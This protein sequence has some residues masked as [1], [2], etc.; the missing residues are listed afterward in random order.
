MTLSSRSTRYFALALLAI[1]LLLPLPAQGGPA[2]SPSPAPTTI[3]CG[4]DQATNTCGGACDA[5]LA[6][7]FVSTGCEC[8]PSNSLCALS[9]QTTGGPLPMCLG[10][11]PGAN[12]VCQL[13]ATRAGAP[14]C[15][16]LGQATATPTPTA[17]PTDTATPTP[18][19]TVT[20]TPTATPTDTATPSP[21][22][23]ATVAAATLT[24]PP[25]TP[26]PLKHFAC[27]EVHAGPFEPRTVL[28]SDQ[29]ND[30]QDPTTVRVRPPKR[31]CNPA[32]KNDEDPTALQDPDHLVAYPI[33]QTAPRFRTIR[34][35]VV[36]DQFGTLVLDV[37]R[38][39]QLLVPSAKSDT[40]PPAP[41]TPTIDHFKCYRVKGDRRR[42]T[43]VTIDDQFGAITVDIKRPRRLC[44]PAVKNG[45]GAL[46]DAVDH[47]MCYEVRLRAGSAFSGGG[48][49]FIDNQ[50]GPDRFGGF[51]PRELCVPAAKN[52]L[53]ATPTP[54]APTPTAS[55]TPT[56]PC[57]ANPTTG[58]CGGTCPNAGDSCVFVPKGSPAC[59]CKPASQVCSAEHA[60]MC[61]G[62]L[63]ADPHFF[64]ISIGGPQ[65]QSCECN[66][67]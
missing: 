21:T 32:S 18:L 49:L 4:L 14:I 12:E 26:T 29:F 54:G 43:N 58:V 50:F 20:P 45:E 44:V 60:P 55:P 37:I 3:A 35:V 17:T 52:F 59:Q 42:V 8:V 41:I 7:A 64:C 24:P 53:G 30:P 65:G 10:F 31:I 11:C 66:N 33:K 25:P 27:Y 22:A 62:F 2:A 15:V 9:P 34:G 56:G 47:L 48:D 36:I 16:C 63:C 38:P 28:L 23:T 19:E 39:E 40:A 46:L 5:G 6:C 51:R 13:S 57:A 67:G 1:M 61:S